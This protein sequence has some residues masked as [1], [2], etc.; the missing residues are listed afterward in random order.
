MDVEINIEINNTQ[1]INPEQ[2]KNNQND[3]I[4]INKNDIK[5]TKKDNPVDLNAINPTLKD[6][7]NEIVTILKENYIINNPTKFL[8]RRNNPHNKRYNKQKTKI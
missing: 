1:G 5:V 6:I 7:I 3:S 4:Q 2:I 8:K